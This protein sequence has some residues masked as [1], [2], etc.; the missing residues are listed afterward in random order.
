MVLT[1]EDDHL[2]LSPRQLAAQGLGAFH[3]AES[4]ANN[5]DA[6]PGHCLWLCTK[7]WRLP[8]TARQS[9]EFRVW[10]E[11]PGKDIDVFPNADANFLT[12]LPVSGKTFSLDQP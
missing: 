12:D 3:A 9:P 11:R 2:G 5:D 8:S 10:V 6:R 1:I 7:A 4:A